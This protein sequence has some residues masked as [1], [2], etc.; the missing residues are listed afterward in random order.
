M[1]TSRHVVPSVAVLAKMELQGII[2]QFSHGN[3]FSPVLQ[4]HVEHGQGAEAKATG[5]EHMTNAQ[6]QALIS[7]KARRLGLQSDKEVIDVEVRG[8]ES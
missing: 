8:T 2:R 5:L 7:E 6:L 3:N 1:L 4:G